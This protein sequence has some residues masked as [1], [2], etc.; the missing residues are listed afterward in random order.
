M[1][2]EDDVDSTEKTPLSRF[3]I[4]DKVQAIHLISDESVNKLL[5]GDNCVLGTKCAACPNDRD[6]EE[7]FGSVKVARET[8]QNFRKKYW[9]YKT[10][11]GQIFTRRKQLYND[12]DAMKVYNTETCKLH[13]EYKIDGIFVCK[14]FFHVSI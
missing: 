6:C 2:L 13:I 14:R 1:D 7:M 5:I 9:D 12:I 8:I 4:S 10:E 11:V 3:K